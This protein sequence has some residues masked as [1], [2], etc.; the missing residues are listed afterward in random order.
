MNIKNKIWLICLYKTLK[1]DD[2]IKSK[3]Y[4]ITVAIVLSIS[5]FSI[6][7]GYYLFSPDEKENNLRPGDMVTNQIYPSL[8]EEID[9][10]I[11]NQSDSTTITPDTEIQ[12]NYKKNGVVT[13]TVSRTADNMFLNLTEEQ[14]KNT[15]NDINV[16]QFSDELVVIEKE[17]FDNSPYFVVGNNNGYI[18]IFYVDSE[19]NVTLQNETDV[20]LK[21]LPEEDVKMLNQGIIVEDN[22][23][24]IRIIEDY[25]S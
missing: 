15:F 8:P 4:I 11:I 7:F 21:T 24:L 25:T 2:N 20:P 5:F 22:T 19:N 17:T 6:Y 12:Y 23:E 14:L 3:K 16:L 1:G 10:E 13:K 9:T 18:G